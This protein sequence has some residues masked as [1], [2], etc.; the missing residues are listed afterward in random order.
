MLEPRPQIVAVELPGGLE[1]AYRSGDCA[2]ARN[3]GDP[4]P[5]IRRTTNAA[6][7]VPVEPADPFTEAVRTAA[8]IGAEVIFLEADHG[9]RPHVPDTYPDT[10]AVRRIGLD[11]YI[12]AYRVYP[13]PRNEEI[14]AHAAAMAWKLQ[15]ADPAG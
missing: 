9:D 10:Y 15:G 5:E 6:I 13:Q 12:E 3:V 1:E 2:A 7:Y 4:L 11:R 8:E 14:A